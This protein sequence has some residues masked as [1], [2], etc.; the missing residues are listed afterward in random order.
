[1]PLVYCTQWPRPSWAS[2][3]TA[4]R[5][6]VSA[7][8]RS[9]SCVVR[10]AVRTRWPLWWSVIAP[11]TSTSRCSPRSW[12]SR[13]PTPKSPPWPTSPSPPLPGA[14]LNA[15]STTPSFRYQHYVQ[16][17]FQVPALCAGLDP[18]TSILIQVPALCAGLDSGTSIMCRSWFRYQHYVQVLIQ[19]P[20]LCAGLDSGTSIMCSSEV[21]THISITK[22]KYVL[23]WKRF[24]PNFRPWGLC[25]GLPFLR[26]CK[27]KT[28]IPNGL[29]LH[30]SLHFYTSAKRKQ[31][32]LW[33]QYIHSR[34][35]A[36]M[37]SHKSGVAIT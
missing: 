29:N 20:A 21:P 16:V 10:C 1:M 9:P 14:W 36:W 25:Q 35:E 12:R 5:C 11:S 19:V 23:Y 6:T 34:L 8:Q 7:A 27:E 32:I 18:G 30:F 3:R 31:Y 33:K 28:V 37:K 13:T 15:S 26:S 22:S 24:T 17:L 2:N 4:W